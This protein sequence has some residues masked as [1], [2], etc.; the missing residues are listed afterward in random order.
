MFDIK[1]FYLSINE[2]LP[3][4]ALKY[5]RKHI[6]V[7]KKD[8]DLILHARWSLL[9]DCN[10]AWVKKKEENFDVTMGEYDGAEVCELVCEFA[11][12]SENYYADEIGI[13]RDDMVC[14]F[15]KSSV[16]HRLKRLRKIYEISSKR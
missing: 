4:D 7:L 9:F 14:Q 15:S 2:A 1:D 6:K 3:I 5:A 10:K 13:Y 12:L 8:I 11:I 16:V